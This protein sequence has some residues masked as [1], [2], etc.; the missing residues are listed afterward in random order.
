MYDPLTILQTARVNRP[1]RNALEADGQY[2]QAAATREKALEA[3]CTLP[4]VHW[5]TS[6]LDADVALDDWVAAVADARAAEQARE[7]K[8][9][10]SPRPCAGL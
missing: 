7:A 2:V 10:G 5:P 4:A 6:P 8:L 3:Q 9:T 1:Y